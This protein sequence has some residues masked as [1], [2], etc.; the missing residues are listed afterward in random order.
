MHKTQSGGGVT[1]R[2]DVAAAI[3]ADQILDELAWQVRPPRRIPTG[4]NALRSEQSLWQKFKATVDPGSAEEIFL[5]VN[6]RARRRAAE[7]A[8][9][10]DT[11]KGI[12]NWK[13]RELAKE[14]A[15][16]DLA[17]LFRQID[18]PKGEV[19]AIDRD[20]AR[21][22]ISARVR[23]LR[24]QDQIRYD[25][26]WTARQANRDLPA[27][28]AVISHDAIIAQLRAVAATVSPKAD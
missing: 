10:R 9:R 26:A 22:A 14:R 5:P 13:R 21:R 4:R 1:N 6:T 12:R 23:Y 27:P 18:A 20:R 15:A 7:Q 8:D 25:R 3:D 17:N 16:S 11:R 24:D 19:G 28:S 2:S